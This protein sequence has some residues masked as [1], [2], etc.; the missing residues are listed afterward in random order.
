MR[1]VGRSQK[2]ARL[3]G[4]PFLTN[5]RLTKRQGGF[6]LLE[7]ITATMLLSVVVLVFLSS[8]ATASK[9]VSVMDT[10]IEL[11]RLAQSQMEFIL[12][13]PYVAAPIAYPSIAVPSGYAV[14]VETESV[15]GADGN[16]QRV[17]VSVYHNG[18]IRRTLQTFKF[19]Q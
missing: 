17:I 3:P 12:S 5:P 15:Q 16:I 9:S 2:Q 10:R 6:I 8:L 13:E 1:A 11:T 4:S 18:E 7:T 14:S 19:N